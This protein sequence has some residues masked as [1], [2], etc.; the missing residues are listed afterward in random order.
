MHNSVTDRPFGHLAPLHVLR[1]AL[2]WRIRISAVDFAEPVSLFMHAEPVFPGSQQ[3]G[4]NPDVVWD[5]GE[6]LQS[7]I[8]PGLYELFTC[9]CGLASDAGI[10][11]AV[12]VSYPDPHRVVWEMDVV[13]MREVLDPILASEPGFLRWVFERADYEAGV[14]RFIRDLQQAARHRWPVHELPDE[15]IGI[16]TLRTRY[17]QIDALPVD[18]LQPHGGELGLTELLA[19]DADAAWTP[20]PGDISL[21]RRP[22][23]RG[24][25]DALAPAEVPTDFLDAAERRQIAQDRDP[26]ADI[27]R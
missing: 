20:E 21:W 1:G 9:T 13:E 8:R 25:V 12:H 14:R 10:E 2:D 23:W 26:L 17:P 24:F 18:T 5:L 11:G 7:V 27:D 3:P 22:E 15:V 6:L 16:D 4:V 19:L